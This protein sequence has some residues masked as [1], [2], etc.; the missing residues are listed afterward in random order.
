M[1]NTDLLKLSLPPD[2]YDPNGQMIAVELAAEGNALDAAQANAEQLLNEFDPRTVYSLLPD[3]ERLYNLSGSGLSLEQRRAQLLAK[4]NERGGQSRGYYLALAARYGFPN[5]VMTE[6]RRAT[7][8]DNCNSALVGQNDLFVW[9]LSLPATGGS[10]RA[11][12]NSPCNAPLASW[13]HS[14]VEGAISEDRPAHT[15]VLFA[16]A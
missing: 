7:C 8:N 12:C 15:T 16:Y 11:S 3:Y 2:A 6:Y 4:V 14:L 1:N 5:A 10:F 13:G 9:R